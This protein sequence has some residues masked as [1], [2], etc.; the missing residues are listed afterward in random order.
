MPDFNSKN[1]QYKE[2]VKAQGASKLLSFLFII[3]SILFLA[4]LG[5]N[6][7]YRPYIEK[8]VSALEGDLSQLASQIPQDSQSRFQS[9]EKQLIVID[10][11]LA[12]HVLSSKIFPLIEANTNYSTFYKS[13]DFD[14][15]AHKLTLRGVTRDYD[16]LAY[17]ISALEKSS[18]VKGYKITSARLSDGGKVEFDLVLTILADSFK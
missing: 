15:V 16:V 3:F 11:T 13:F 7:G 9:F 5:M 6:F 1:G 8:K 17:Q 2:E 18:F 4:Y 12:N 10:K 14:L